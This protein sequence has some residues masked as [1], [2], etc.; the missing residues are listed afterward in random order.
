V[1]ERDTRRIVEGVTSLK[2]YQVTK[3]CRKLKNTQKIFYEK[4]SYVSSLMNK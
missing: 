2:K 1:K 3:K 4:F